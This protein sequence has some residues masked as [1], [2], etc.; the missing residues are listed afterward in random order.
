MSVELRVFPILD[1]GT[2][3]DAL[4]NARISIRKAREQPD[5]SPQE[6]AKAM[7]QFRI[8]WRK[9]M[10]DLSPECDDL[11]WDPFHEPVKLRRPKRVKSDEFRIW[12][13]WAREH[14]CPQCKGRRVACKTCNGS[15]IDPNYAVL[16][17]V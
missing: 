10:M 7:E 15:R 12:M 14:P 1:R 13:A 5:Y 17:P 3:V 16:E 6:I 2:A 9:R 4:L 11:P 8:G